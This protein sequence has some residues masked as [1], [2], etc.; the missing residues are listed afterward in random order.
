MTK[1]NSLKIKW[2]K[3]IDD[4]LNDL[5]KIKHQ[6]ENTF[7]IAKKEWKVLR[8][9]GLH[10]IDE[11]KK[12]YLELKEHGKGVYAELKKMFELLEESLQHLK[13]AGHEAAV[14]AKD[15]L[16]ELKKSMVEAESVA[17]PKPSTR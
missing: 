2:S 8:E 15:L 13:A 17:D 10:L 1:W 14:D 6:G 3:I 12:T 4:G 16:A 5:N 11:V 7:D 9:K